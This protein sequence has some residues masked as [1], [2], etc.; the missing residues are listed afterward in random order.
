MGKNLTREFSACERRCMIGKVTPD[1]PI[2]R[3]PPNVSCIADYWPQ[4]S[5][6]LSIS[7]LCHTCA[8]IPPGVTYAY[9]FESATA[10]E[11]ASSQPLTPSRS[12]NSTHLAYFNIHS[13]RRDIDI[14]TLPKSGLLTSRSR[15]P[16][17]FP[18]APTECRYDTTG[19]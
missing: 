16:F 2:D 1:T 14:L 7:K 13:N 19:E 10:E 5:P 17:L 8:R 18:S 15:F 4:Y 11:L 9:T 3:H 12:T 6:Q